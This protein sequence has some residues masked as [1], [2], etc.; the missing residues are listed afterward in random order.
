MYPIVSNEQYKKDRMLPSEV[1]ENYY[2]YLVRLGYKLSPL[3]EF[4]KNAISVKTQL[5]V[6]VGLDN[7]Y[8]NRCRICNK[9][10]DTPY[11]RAYNCWSCEK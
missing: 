6:I 4:R 1:E 9:L 7:I 10:F 2:N 11:K 8:N 5:D 3:S